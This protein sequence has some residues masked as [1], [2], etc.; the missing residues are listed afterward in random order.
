MILSRIVPLPPALLCCGSSDFLLPSSTLVHAR[1]GAL[2][3]KSTLRVYPGHHA[4]F[5][6]PPGWT[7]HMCYENSVP[8]ARHILD[9]LEGASKPPR[10][11]P[12]ADSF[13]RGRMQVPKLEWWAPLVGLEVVLFLPLS[14]ALTP[15]L[16]GKALLLAWRTGGAA[17]SAN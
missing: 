6:L 13:V 12:P 7:W 14:I 15:L 5:G 3:C 4:F 2:G 8:C 10:S 11:P 17:L 1:L 9:F 16:A